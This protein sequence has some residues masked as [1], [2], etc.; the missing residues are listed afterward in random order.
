MVVFDFGRGNNMYFENCTTASTS[1][2]YYTPVAFQEAVSA[3]VVSV[4]VWA[5][6]MLA[7]VA[8]WFEPA[9]LPLPEGRESL[10]LAA[11]R[12]VVARGFVGWVRRGT[13]RPL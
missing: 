8:R 4:K 6:M 5:R 2:N 13:R 7:R 12:V 1:F 9:P 3:I 10:C 11:R